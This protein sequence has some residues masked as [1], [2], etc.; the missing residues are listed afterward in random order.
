MDQR[1]TAVLLAGL[2]LA[3]SAGCGGGGGGGEASEPATPAA[4]ERAAAG[5]TLPSVV[6]ESGVPA[7]SDASAIAFTNVSIAAMLEEAIVPQQTV[8]VENGIIV[9]IGPEG[10]M[11]ASPGIR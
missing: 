5:P 8:L 10:S 6:D 11:S 3:M 9:A 7:S 2:G 4:V 1:K